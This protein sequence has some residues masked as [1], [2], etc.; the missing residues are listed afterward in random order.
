M[1]EKN[2][3]AVIIEERSAFV[4]MEIREMLLVK[5]NP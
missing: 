3:S 4:K 1:Y 5:E 2:E